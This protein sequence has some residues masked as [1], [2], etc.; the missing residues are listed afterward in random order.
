MTISNRQYFLALVLL[1]KISSHRQSYFP[2]KSYNFFKNIFEYFVCVLCLFF[3]SVHY[4]TPLWDNRDV[5]VVFDTHALV[6]HPHNFVWQYYRVWS[7]GKCNVRYPLV[8]YGL[9][10][11]G[12]FDRM[13][14]NQE[15]LHILVA[16]WTKKCLSKIND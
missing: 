8:W 7:F 14:L 12:C 5:V 3:F 6:Q 15:L 10:S 1:V 9:I 11:S 2:K 4:S 16:S 13:W